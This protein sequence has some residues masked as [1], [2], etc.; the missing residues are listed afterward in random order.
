[1]LE[2]W[3]G[4]QCSWPK[5][6]IF[7]ELKWIL[8]DYLVKMSHFTDP[9]LKSASTTHRIP[10][11]LHYKLIICPHVDH[12]NIKIIKYTN[13]NKS[14]HRTKLSRSTTFVHPN[15]HSWWMRKQQNKTE[16]FSFF[17]LLA[18]EL[19]KPKHNEK[20]CVHKKWIF[21]YACCTNWCQMDSHGIS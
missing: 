6:T 7:V 15:P 20:N 12:K 13:Q 16:I 14:I 9:E 3:S 18:H 4:I 11:Y 2:S 17:I 19:K 10:P 21:T 8:H 1:M 5:I